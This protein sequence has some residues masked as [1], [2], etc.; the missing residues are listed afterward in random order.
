MAPG[1]G[2]KNAEKLLGGGPTI[3]IGQESW[4][5]P[6]AGFFKWMV[7]LICQDFFGIVRLLVLG[8]PGIFL[9]GWSVTFFLDLTLIFW[10]KQGKGGG[11]LKV[12][13]RV[14]VLSSVL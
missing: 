5:L 6:Y 11:G 12:F 7:S 13:K 3:R 14:F 10:P 8:S 2:K 1:R 9:L 4:C